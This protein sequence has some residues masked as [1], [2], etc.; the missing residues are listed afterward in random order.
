MVIVKSNRYIPIEPLSNIITRSGGRCETCKGQF[1]TL[2]GTKKA[3]PF[4]IHHNDTNTENNEED[5][6]KLLCRSC[7]K[8]EHKE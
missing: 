5:N 4:E 1:I 2:T 3:I 6:L 7:H 8:E